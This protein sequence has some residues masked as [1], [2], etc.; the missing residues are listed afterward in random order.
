[1]LDEIVIPVKLEL[2]SGSSVQSGAG[3]QEYTVIV[4]RLLSHSLTASAALK[5]SSSTALA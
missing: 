1:M 2:S 4:F 3:A 5:A